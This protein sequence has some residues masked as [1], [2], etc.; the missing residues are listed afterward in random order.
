MTTLSTFGGPLRTRSYPP[1]P[2][3][4]FVAPAMIGVLLSTQTGCLTSAL[5][6]LGEGT[7]ATPRTEQPVAYTQ[8]V[9][10]GRF[11]ELQFNSTLDADGNVHSNAPA[12]DA[13]GRVRSSPPSATRVDLGSVYW[14]GFMDGP[15]DP[16]CSREMWQRLLPSAP[17][18]PPPG[19]VPI[20]PA[21]H[22]DVIA[23]HKQMATGFPPM[24]VQ[25]NGIDAWI[26]CGAGD[27]IGYAE[28]PTP[29][30]PQAG[31]EGGRSAGA[32]VAI[33]ILFPFALAADIVGA[34]FYAAICLS[35]SG[36][37]L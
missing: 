10:D 8:A 34:V 27:A 22:R 16:Y 28:A 7:P 35:G 9:R 5:L 4:K 37:K 33:V 18:Q 32:V 2:R 29:P 30:P 25:L 3:S 31:S 36:C 24:T 15:L 12:L 14:R 13:D 17:P 20:R 11:V 21:D 19:L 1:N 26:V 23:L 6:K